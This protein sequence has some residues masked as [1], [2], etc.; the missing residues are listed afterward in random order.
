MSA[1]S[2]FT[3]A[4]APLR[5]HASRFVP[6]ACILLFWAISIFNLDRFPDLND[7]EAWI[8]SPGYKLFTQ[9]IYGSDLLAGFHHIELRY[10]EFLPLMALLQGAS[11]RLFGVG[12]FQLR[13]L[14]VALGALTLV[15][16]YPIARKLFD[17]KVAVLAMG[18]LLVWQWTPAGIHPF[19]SGI[20]LID[21]SRLARYDILVPPLG[22]AAWWCF[23]RARETNRIRY[24][25]LSGVFVGLAG[26]AHMY[27]LFWGV[28]LLFI[29]VL[30][31]LPPFALRHAKAPLR[32]SPF[33]LRYTKAPL[34]CSLFASLLGITL[35]WLPWLIATG[36][37]RD[38]YLGQN[39]QYSD[40]FALFNMS[41]YLTN[42]LTEPRRYHLGIGELS[43]FTRAGFWLL[44]VGV[45]IAFAWLG[46]R[47]VRER[48]RTALWLLVPSLMLPLLFALLIKVKQYNYVATLVPLFVI[49]M[50]WALTR[51]WQTSHR[52]RLVT[53]VLLTWTIVQGA[54]GWMQLPWS[55]NQATSPTVF[56]AELRGIVPPRAR[57]LGLPRYWLALTDHEYRSWV[58][59]FDL[60]ST[61]IS[62]QPITLD[63]A[64]EQVAPQIILFDPRTIGFLTA[65]D[66]PTDEAISQTLS[67]YLQHH[68]AR[69]I[70]ELRDHHG[71][72]VQ[73]YQLDP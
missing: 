7:D 71:A 19:A 9:G 13:F 48:Q 59:P 50:A 62:Q 22:L 28:T 5:C 52:L 47:V 51:L 61:R 39:L 66:T 6:L 17:T 1:F 26:L 57:V 2:R 54:Y 72:L 3:F 32:P 36:W 4:K 64:F 58:L 68:H 42:L 45:P 69:L 21:L 14:P 60:A 27:G 55:A 43:T 44:V 18:L 73:V 63:A 53:M 40:R 31:C 16:T 23:M 67:A 56:F 70:G 30:D 34:R 10:F 38:D 8:L 33:A 15:L 35:A 41:F 20:P 49:V 65:H 24:D 46:V 11:T 29:L 37:Y 25:F 12:V